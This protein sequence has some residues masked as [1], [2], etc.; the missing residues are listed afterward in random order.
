MVNSID[1]FALELDTIIASR[2]DALAEWLRR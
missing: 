2:Y 1:L